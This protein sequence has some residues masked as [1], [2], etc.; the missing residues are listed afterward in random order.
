MVVLEGS[1]AKLSSDLPGVLTEAIASA[2]KGAEDTKTMRAQAGRAS[3][4]AAE[5]VV[6]ISIDC[7][8]FVIL[9]RWSMRTLELWRPQP[10]SV[11]SVKLSHNQM[12]N[13]RH[14]FYLMSVSKS[15][16]SGCQMSN[17]CPHV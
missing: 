3:Y 12:S 9:S 11:L 17:V 6:N 10:G 5:K 2:S 1:A 4:V 16:L 15:S 7:T 14:C 8:I 13:N